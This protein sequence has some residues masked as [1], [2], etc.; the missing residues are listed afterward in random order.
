MVSIDPTT[1]KVRAM[2][3]GTGFSSAAG[4]HFNIITEGNRQPGSG[5]KIFTLLAALERGYSIY[6]T[7]DGQSPCAVKFPG[8]NDLVSHP[9]NND[10][11]N[12]GGVLTLLNAT[13]QS[14]NC[15]YVRL[16]HEVGLANVASMAKQLGITTNLAIGP[17]VYPPS[18]VIGSEAVPP[19]EMADAYATVADNGVYHAPSF[20]DHI[21]DRS[22]STIY[23]GA[24]PAKRVIPAQI[25]AEATVAFQAVIQNG[26]GTAAQLYN[27]PAA[28]KTGTTSSSVDAWFNGFTPQLE[29]TVWMGNL[30]GEVPMYDV[31]GV[32]EVYG[33]TFPT[34]TWHDFMAA[35]LADQPVLDFAPLNRATLP[36]THFITSPSLV[37]DDV[38]DHNGGGYGCYNS[39]YKSSYNSYGSG[40]NGYGYGPGYGSGSTY[41]RT[42][43]PSTSPTS[44]PV[45]VSTPPS[46]TPTGPPNGGRHHGPPTT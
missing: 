44:P 6:D 14:T 40:C 42:T 34:I 18:M 9:I 10:E 25:A 16:A 36:P 3:G 38:L 27:R 23:S 11:G 31:G 41:P 26:T 21:V 39:S 13:A 2:V 24:A 35:A 46:T 37:A 8:D 19:I 1:G 30:A 12:G 15:A 32:Y 17:G 5:F 4:S 22:G 43:A 33:G 28:G 7:V 20:I 29:T 45:S